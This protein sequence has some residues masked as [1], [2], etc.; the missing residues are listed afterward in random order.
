MLKKKEDKLWS[1]YIN[2]R[3]DLSYARYVRCRNDLRRLTIGVA[4]VLRLGGQ[5]STYVN[6]PPVKN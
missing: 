1:A 5:M 2:S 6:L 4:R 3:D